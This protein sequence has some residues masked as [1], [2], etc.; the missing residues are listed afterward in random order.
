MIEYRAISEEGRYHTFKDNP[1][2]KGI[3]AAF[4]CVAEHQER[5]K[6]YPNYKHEGAW[7]VEQRTISDWTPVDQGGGVVSDEQLLKAAEAWVKEW[8]DNWPQTISNDADTA[9]ACLLACAKAFVGVLDK[10]DS[11]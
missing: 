2:R 10:G 5:Q 9:R 6:L 11:K 3:D 4:E 8:N 7:R 1:R